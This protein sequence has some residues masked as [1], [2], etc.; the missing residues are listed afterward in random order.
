MSFLTD[1]AQY[2]EKEINNKTIIKLFIAL[3]DLLTIF[4]P[5]K[6]IKWIKEAEIYQVSEHST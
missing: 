5:H 4:V 6:C 3:V 1:F 2:M